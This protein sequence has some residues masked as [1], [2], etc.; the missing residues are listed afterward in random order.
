VVAAVI[1]DPAIAAEL[2]MST[3]TILPSIILADATE[4]LANS[5]APIASTAICAAVMVSSA[6]LAAVICLSLTLAVTILFV[7]SSCRA[8]KHWS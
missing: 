1:L 2:L 4:S 8:Y 7:C 3:L 6:I 5:L